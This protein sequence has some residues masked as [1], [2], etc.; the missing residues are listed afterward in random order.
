MLCSI[1]LSSY[2]G[3]KYIYQQL[4]SIQKQTRQPD[5]VLIFDDCSKDKTQ[6]IIEEFIK[7]NDLKNWKLVANNQNLGWKRNF[8]Q[9]IEQA[10]ND[11]IFLC[12]QDDIW[13]EDKI[14]KMM[15]AMED[16]SQ[17]ELLACEYTPLYDDE[18][19]KRIS[20]KILKSMKESG[21]VKKME[22]DSNW[23]YVLRPGCTYAISKK[24]YS[25]AKNLW[26]KEFAHDM[27]L[28][29]MALLRK[30][31]Y[32][33]EE[34]LI[35]W[36]RYSAS[37]SN[38][39]NVYSQS[40]DIFSRLYD[41]KIDIIESDILF[42]KKTMEYINQ[43][44]VLDSYK[45]V[46]DNLDFRLQCKEAFQKYNFIKMFIVALKY[47]RFYYAYKTIVYDIFLIIVSFLKNFRC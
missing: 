26:D 9:G 32:H 33:F 7:Q 25:V 12:D 43:G 14:E 42:L 24:L 23:M 22:L 11:V 1:V 31:A 44:Y 38:P 6:N 5:E 13:K 47:K 10:T 2:N 34:K 20:P 37:S 4:D 21:E 18:V 39:L 3:E 19:T 40:K 30:T 27:V 28:W 15:K 45:L 41:E 17:I 8:W 46:K 29:R 36:R 16:N 35:Y